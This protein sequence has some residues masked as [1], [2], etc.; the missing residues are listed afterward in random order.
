MVAL[1]LAAFGAMSKDPAK[2]TIDFELFD[3]LSSF[4]RETK[5]QTR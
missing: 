5:S 1:P 2:L 3:D 4:L